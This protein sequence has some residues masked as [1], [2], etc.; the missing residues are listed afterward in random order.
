MS[1]C[2]SNQKEQSLSFGVLWAWP[3][4]TTSKII[5]ENGN[6]LN[7][8]FDHHLDLYFFLQK[9]FYSSP[10]LKR[11]APEKKCTDVTF[12]HEMTHL[13]IDEICGGACGNHIYVSRR[14]N[15]YTYR[16]VC[17]YHI[18]LYVYIYI[19]IYNIYIYIH[20]V[21]HICNDILYVYT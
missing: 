5:K 12:L 21:Y 6:E 17:I 10:E 14:M 1:I 20:I 19:Y 8:E 4:A 9:L 13:S 7:C 2:L 16:M 15:K 3:S 11:E 18:Y